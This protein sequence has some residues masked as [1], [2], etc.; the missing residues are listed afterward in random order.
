MGEGVG[1]AAMDERDKQLSDAL[2][3]WVVFVPHDLPREEALRAIGD[4]LAAA[5]VR[6]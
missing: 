5:Q 4:E 6:V 1:G 2:R 3:A